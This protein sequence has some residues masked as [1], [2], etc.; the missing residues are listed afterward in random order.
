[1]ATASDPQL[2]N[3]FSEYSIQ[4]LAQLYFAIDEAP[5]VNQFYTNFSWNVVD[6]V[7]VDGN[8]KVIKMETKG[9][10][11]VSSKFFKRGYR[12]VAERES[13][14][15]VVLLCEGENSRA[16]KQKIEAYWGDIQGALQRSL[17][18]KSAIQTI[19][20]R[21]MGYYQ[22]PTSVVAGFDSIQGQASS[23]FYQTIH[24]GTIRKRGNT[25]KVSEFYFNDA[26][27]IPNLHVGVA[28]CA[29]PYQKFLTKGTLPRPKGFVSKLFENNKKKMM[30]M[31]VNYINEMEMDE[32]RRSLAK[33]VNDCYL[34][35]LRY[36]HGSV[37][38]M[39][40][41]VYS[42]EDSIAIKK[43]LVEDLS[44]KFYTTQPEHMKILQDKIDTLTDNEKE[45]LDVLKQFEEKLC[46]PPENQNQ[47]VLLYIHG[48]NNSVEECLLRAS[49]IACDIGFG[50]RLAVFSWPSLESAVRYFQDKDQID[51]AVRKFLD[52]LVML[53]RSARK[54]HIIAH[55]AANLL[56]TRSALAASAI[57]AQ[58]KGKIGQLICAHADVKVEFFLEVF[59]DSD[60]VAGIESI[61][62]NVTVYYHQRDKA[63][64]W[65]SAICGIGDRIGR[66]ET[67]QLPNE[68]KLENINIGEMSIAKETFLYFV[69]SISSIKHNVYAE[70]PLVLED[71]SEVI[72]KGFKA[73]QR[74]HIN[75]A[76]S[77]FI[78]KAHDVTTKP[79]CH[80]CGEKYEYV[81]DSFVL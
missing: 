42:E 53:C 30:P 63:L 50:G 10:A 33:N 77:C 61:V 75:V 58:C 2:D 32:F 55:S 60:T 4:T 18:I 64:W 3:S 11:V 14:H 45:Y 76:C 26:D 48:F 46:N 51:L 1:M 24:Y 59:K 29:I 73:H 28:Q 67:R 71:M 25:D 19:E 17:V 47:D 21:E 66:Q 37:E 12:V 38:N 69:G 13:N 20:H 49:Q 43:T 62:D 9:M 40:D 31:R 81:L 36:L 72:N 7:A 68:K 8:T 56:F 15:K 52:F 44:R 80:L 34:S 22:E 54:V 41:V 27:K 74:S 6:T 78:V 35:Y 16:G 79:V 65:A 23:E 57:L 70:N 5:P 39:A